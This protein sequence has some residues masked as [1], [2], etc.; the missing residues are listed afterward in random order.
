MELRPVLGPTFLATLV[1]MDT[2][3]LVAS[4]LKIVQAVVVGLEQL[5]GLG[6]PL[7]RVLVGM[8]FTKP[9]Y[10]LLFTRSPVS[11]GKHTGT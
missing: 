5:A 7:W 9:Q 2:V 1:E 11:L 3:L 6:L 10:L 8:G 4:L